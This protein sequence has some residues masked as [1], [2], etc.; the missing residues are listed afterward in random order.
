MLYNAGMCLSHSK[1]RLELLVYCAARGGVE[2]GVT[3]EVCACPASQ[4]LLYLSLRDW[5]TTSDSTLSMGGCMR[6]CFVTPWNAAASAS[7]CRTT[8]TGGSFLIIGTCQ[9]GTRP[10]SVGWQAGP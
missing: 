5:S 4:A 9:Q 2:G 1:Y 10:L 3:W 8:R 6:W 7:T